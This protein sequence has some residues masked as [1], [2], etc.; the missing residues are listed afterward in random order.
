MVTYGEASQFAT[1]LNYYGRETR[2]PCCTTM[3]FRF[4]IR[5]T[6]R[7]PW[8]LSAA[9]VFADSFVS[10]HGLACTREVTTSVV[11]C[12]L[13]Q[14][15]TLRKEYLKGPSTIKK[16][17]YNRK[18]DVSWV[19]HV[20]L[21]KVLNMFCKLFFRQLEMVNRHPL[22]RTHVNLLEH[23][24]I[25]GMSSDES[26]HEEA[27]HDRVAGSW[28]ATYSVLTPQWRA[29]ELAPW[30]HILDVAYVIVRRAGAELQGDY[31]QNRLYD[32]R[33]IRYSNSLKFV[34]ALPINVYDPQWLEANNNICQVDNSYYSFVHTNEFIW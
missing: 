14:M 8:N 15:K 18:H 19:M 24:G 27:R 17:R 2:G 21:I 10:H 3:Q 22:L 30:L 23:L 6:P 5:G 9:H 25:D 26:D 28:A 33:S 32:E 7:S 13:T 31:P 12:F 4:N 16:R 29:W 34:D 20:H 1:T 11:K